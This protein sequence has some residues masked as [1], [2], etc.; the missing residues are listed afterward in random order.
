ML[1]PANIIDQT[2]QAELE[3]LV[4]EGELEDEGGGKCSDYLPRWRVLLFDLL[5]HISE[6]VTRCLQC[7][8]H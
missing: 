5:A 8:L 3:E 6:R 7:I 2:S 1:A 4:T